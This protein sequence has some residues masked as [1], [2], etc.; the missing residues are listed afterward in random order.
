MEIERVLSC[1]FES[2]IHY[3]YNKT[4]KK[5]KWAV[6]FMLSQENLSGFHGKM[7]FVGKRLPK[8]L[9]RKDGIRIHIFTH[10]KLFKNILVSWENKCSCLKI[11]VWAFIQKKKQSSFTYLLRTF[12]VIKDKVALITVL[13]FNA[14]AIDTSMYFCNLFK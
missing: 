12:N 6:W 13:Q 2:L 5:V 1:M 7:F 14:P 4:Q 10:W 9:F 3:L 8:D 11:P